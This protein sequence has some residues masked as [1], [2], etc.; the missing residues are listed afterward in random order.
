MRFIF[1]IIFIITA[2]LLF[3][4]LIDP[5]YQNVLELREQEAQFASALTKSQELKEVREKLLT[6]YNN[7]SS[8]DLEDLN[9]MLPDNIDNVRLIL[10]LDNLA[11]L[12]NIRLSDVSVD[13]TG[14]SQQEEGAI[15]TSNGGDT[16]GSVT[17][18]FSV[19]TTYENFKKFLSDLERSLRLVDVTQLQVTPGDGNYN[20]QMSVRTY[21]LK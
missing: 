3:F 13:L 9:K 19:Q 12:H 16:Y 1:P 7:F 21:W 18:S 2:I 17:L 4:A 8:E 5:S 14:S 11:R 20:Y 6:K 15:A 10:D